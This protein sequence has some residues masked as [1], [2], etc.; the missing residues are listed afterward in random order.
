VYWCDYKSVGQYVKQHIRQDDLIF[1]MM[2]HTLQRYAGVTNGYGLMTLLAKTMV[3]DKV[4]LSYGFM[5][6]YVGDPIVTTFDE[7]ILLLGRYNRIWIVGAPASLVSAQ[8]DTQ[9]LD[10]INRNFRVVYEGYGTRVY[11]WEK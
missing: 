3:Y 5:D 4:D 8:N 11:L 10:Y 1:S 2:P 7:F 9:T 6:K